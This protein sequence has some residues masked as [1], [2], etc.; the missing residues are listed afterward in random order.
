MTQPT[1]RYQG[2]VRGGTLIGAPALKVPPLT[3]DIEHFY[4][5]S[6][7]FGRPTLSLPTYHVTGT[8]RGSSVC[9]VSKR[10]SRREEVSSEEVS[11]ERGYAEQVLNN[12]PKIRKRIKKEQ[13]LNNVPKIRKRIKN[14]ATYRNLSDCLRV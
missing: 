13:V 11:S 5:G 12:V 1:I 9:H 7:R 8:W 6:R 2:S 4:S 3:P 10:R 14:H